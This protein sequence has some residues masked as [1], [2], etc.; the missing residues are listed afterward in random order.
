MFVPAC[1]DMFPPDV[2]PYGVYG[3]G[4]SGPVVFLVIFLQIVVE[5]AMPPASVILTERAELF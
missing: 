1:R 5:V 2:Q 4:I 3:N